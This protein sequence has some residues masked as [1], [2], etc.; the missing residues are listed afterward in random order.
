M[1]ALIY[2]I[3]GL[4]VINLTFAA[5]VVLLRTHNVRRGA[6][7]DVRKRVWYPRIIGFLSDDSDAEDL[8]A[9]VTHYEQRD[10]VEVSWDIARRLRG[11]DRA[12]VQLFAAPL[13]D[14]TTLDLEA[15]RSE[16]RARALQIVSCLGG[17]IYEPATVAFLD[18]RSSLV[19]VVAARALCQ[20]SRAQWINEVLDRLGRYESWSVALTASMLENAGMGAAPAMREYLGDGRRPAFARAAV[21][22]S[23]MLLKDAEAA[24]VAAD[25]LT[26]ANPELVAACLRLLAAV[27]SETHADAVRP[28]I[29]DDRFFV[30]AEAMTVL[31]KL[32]E[33]RDAEAIVAAIEIDS[34]WIA[35]RAASALAE[36]HATDELAT[37]VNAGGLPAEAA[38]ET[39]YGGVA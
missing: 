30:R 10:V 8:R 9:S 32:G 24:D 18:D 13:L 5:V 20:P 3:L 23:L 25:Q 28:L 36:L 17:D 22:R 14:E 35:I 12:R 33:P 11:S 27:G 15:R 39:L 16:T 2:A 7:L 21:A 31:G 6:R 26:N 37:L 29:N 1:S 4:A 38:V 34:P 19:S